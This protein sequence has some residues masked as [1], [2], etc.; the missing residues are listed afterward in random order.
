MENYA[1]GSLDRKTVLIDLMVT[2]EPDVWNYAFSLTRSEELANDI[3]QE[4][5]VKAYEKLDS[6]RGESSIKTWLLVITR[7]TVINYRR[8]AFFRKVILIDYMF[9][10]GTHPSAEKEVLDKIVIED[11]WR[12]ILNLPI[13]LREVLVLYVQQHLSIS[14]IACLI[15]VSEATVKSRLYRARNKVSNFLKQEGDLDGKA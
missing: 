2:H 8:S 7:N 12:I 4:V 11:I 6:F 1:G 13:K 3:T 15:G 14:E 5:F 9:D 10:R